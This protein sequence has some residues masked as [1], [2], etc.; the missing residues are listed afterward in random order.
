M[1]RP[2]EMTRV[3][4]ETPAASHGSRTLIVNE[5]HEE[6]TESDN[7][8]AEPVGVLRLTGDMSSRRPRSIRWDESVVDN[9]HMN[10]KKTKICCIYHKPHVVGESDT[11]SSSSDDDSSS[12]DSDDDRARHSNNCNHRRK[13]KN[14]REVSPNAYERQPVYKDR[15]QPS[16][17]S[18]P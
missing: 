14:P 13:K 8:N 15:P 11:E 17:S 5:I 2:V 7:D 16:S 6:Q 9:E 18:K 4:E 12:S 1:S 3:R 10:K